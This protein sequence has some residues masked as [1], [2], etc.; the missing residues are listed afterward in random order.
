[1]PLKR[2][3]GSIPVLGTKIFLW[4]YHKRM[5][6]PFLETNQSQTLSQPQSVELN[7]IAEQ[8]RKSEEK[9]AKLKETG[10][11]IQI[12][13]QDKPRFLRS[14]LPENRGG[15]GEIYLGYDK[16][17]DRLVA[18]KTLRPIEDLNR[19][20]EQTLSSWDYELL[21]QQLV[22]EAKI[23][24]QARQDCPFVVAPY[25][26]IDNENL[27]SA[28]GKT[29]LIMEWVEGATF[30]EYFEKNTG[31]R[32]D[33]GQTPESVSENFAKYLGN[34][35]QIFSDVATACDYM[36]FK[37][38]MLHYDLKPNNIFVD[39]NGRARVID[40]GLAGKPISKKEFDDKDEFWGSVSYVSPERIPG[41]GLNVGKHNIKSEVFSLA[42]IAFE[43][44]TGE[45]L[46]D[47]ISHA[48]IMFQISYFDVKPRIEEEI[49][50]GF[51][52]KDPNR[53]ITEEQISNIIRVLQKATEK[54]L[55]IL[56]IRYETATEFANAF[57]AALGVSVE[58]EMRDPRHLATKNPAG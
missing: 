24:A 34:L 52:R 54:N 13:G 6:S 30:K 58:K 12:I 3:A 31:H 8:K 27:K 5:S 35:A 44:I 9:I 47:G 49:R 53:I 11:A 22:K 4:C 17:L 40:F 37:R 2:R 10:V 15:L 36:W 33:V 42:S 48:N 26:L 51:L 39:E 38:G 50:K 28:D 45:A 16:K 57:C 7:P 29:M 21:Q 43:A 18:I 20:F 56:D 46:F 41:S 19:V 55:N 23:L 1:M 25:E 32:R 14:E